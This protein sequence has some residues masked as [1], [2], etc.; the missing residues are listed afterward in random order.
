MKI[1]LDYVGRQVR[2]TDERLQHILEHSEMSVMETE[3]EETVREPQSVVQSLSDE[4]ASLFYRHYTATKV[5]SKWLCVV[6]KYT[7]VDAFIV[8]A[9][10]TD[11]PKK[12]LPL[13]PNK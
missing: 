12:G 11:Q 7:I 1:I 3:L 8:T 5:G 4:T 6:V 9:Y 2:L 10:L 13:W